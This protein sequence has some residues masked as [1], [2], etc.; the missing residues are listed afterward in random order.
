MKAIIYVLVAVS[1][2]VLFLGFWVGAAYLYGVQ[3][4]VDYGSGGGLPGVAGGPSRSWVTPDWGY[5][6]GVAVVLLAIVVAVATAITV[7]I[8]RGRRI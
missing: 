6:A 1:A 3:S 7:V 2:L 4:F 8:R 5:G